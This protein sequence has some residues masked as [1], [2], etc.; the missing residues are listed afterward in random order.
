MDG[1]KFYVNMVADFDLQLFKDCCPIT[2]ATNL[3]ECV[4]LNEKK[5]EKGVI[6]RC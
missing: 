3:Q 5:S 6:S 4:A 2:I 1:R